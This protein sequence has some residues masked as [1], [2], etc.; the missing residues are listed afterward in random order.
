MPLSL[1]LQNHHHL[2]AFEVGLLI[3]PQPLAFSAAAALG[4]RAVGRFGPGLAL[5]AGMLVMSSSLVA[6]AVSETVPL[7][8]RVGLAMLGVGVGMALSFP[9]ASIGAVDA[10]PESLRGTTAGLMVACDLD[11]TL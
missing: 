4:A 9:A 7:A 3:L 6:L 10:A 8:V 5:G 2:D 1:A 11:G